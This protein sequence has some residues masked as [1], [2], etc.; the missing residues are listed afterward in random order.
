MK[1]DPFKRHRYSPQII[2]L[3]VRWYCRYP[4]SYLDVRDLLAEGGI[5]IDPAT[6]NR[7]VVKFGPLIAKKAKA[8][9]YPRSM[10]WH[11]DEAY[12]RVSGKW[13]YLWKIVS[14]KGRFVDSR[15]TARRDTEVAIAFLKAAHKIAVCIGI[16]PV[17]W[18]ER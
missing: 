9:H 12:T 10:F 13:R 4:L 1:L 18:T 3:A 6:V 2:L 16:P 8:I 11:V 15:L 5:H 14:E 7:W 17:S